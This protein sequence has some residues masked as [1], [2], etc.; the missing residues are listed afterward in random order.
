[1]SRKL[2]IVSLL[3]LAVSAA[4]I[5]FEEKPIIETSEHG[6]F[7][8][9][10]TLTAEEQAD[11][12][13]RMEEGRYPDPR[14]APFN[15]CAG[16]KTVRPS[17]HEQSLD[18]KKLYIAAIKC[19][20][21]PERSPSSR[22]PFKG[23]VYDDFVFTHMDTVDRTHFTPGF[24]AYH[25]AFVL[26]YEIALQQC[27][28][29][30]EFENV[31]LPYWDI[32]LD[33]EN[34]AESEL[35]FEEFFGGDGNRAEDNCVQVG[36]FAGSMD[37][38]PKDQ[39][40]RRKFEMHQFVKRANAESTIGAHFCKAELEEHENRSFYYFSKFLS[41]TVHEAL[42]NGIGGDQN[43]MEASVFSSHS[44]PRQTIRSST[45]ITPTLI[46]FGQIG[47]RRSLNSAIN[48]TD[49]MNTGMKFLST[50]K[51][52]SADSRSLCLLG[53]IKMSCEFETCWMSI[54]CVI[55]TLLECVVMKKEN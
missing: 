33:A 36:Q 35:F 53:G 10:G 17:W 46:E 12:A 31:K 26:V 6:L 21:D 25:R 28:G 2:A 19:L 40:L 29:K 24:L 47:K 50:M 51:C 15:D 4:T 49:W 30:G 55:L 8:R 23:S 52:G 41:S 9:E 16:G 5:Q 39:C 54:S 3:L 37:I 14:P 34:P 22:P 13:A 48:M 43:N 44:Y 45:Y 42:H 7:K 32:A 27:G 20:M 11:E 1:M 38:H 18:E